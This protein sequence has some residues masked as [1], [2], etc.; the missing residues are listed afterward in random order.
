M[1]ILGLETNRIRCISS[2]AIS[3]LAAGT[4]P[5]SAQ[6]TPPPPAPVARQI[7]PM[8]APVRRVS[9]RTLPTATTP[10]KALR[11]AQQ[12]AQKSAPVA[13]TAPAVASGPAAAAGLA[14]PAKVGVTAPVPGKIAVYTCRIGQDFSEKLRACITPAVKSGVTK[15]VSSTRNA[16]KRARAK[17]AKAITGDSSGRSALGAKRPR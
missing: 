13:T 12:A 8:V 11:P 2:I 14:S 1:R 9:P 4:A 17:L 3:I 15:V 6:T 7:E 5:V 10:P 16:T